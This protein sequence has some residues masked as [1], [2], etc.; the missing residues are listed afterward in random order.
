MALTKQDNNA[1]Q[2]V[3]KKKTFVKKSRELPDKRKLNPHI[4]QNIERRKRYD[5]KYNV[6]NNGN[7][8]N[9]TT[10]YV[11]THVAHYHQIKKIFDDVI[12]KAKN[13][14]E[15]FGN[16]FECDAII[17]HVTF[18]N[19]S[20]VKHSFVDLS[21]PKLYNALI[22][23]LPNGEPNVKY[24]DIE[25]NGVVFKEEVQLAPIIS[26]GTYE[27]DE[28]QLNFINQD[29]DENDENYVT[30]AMI[31]VSPGFVTL[32]DPEEYNLKSLYVSGDVPLNDM[33]FLMS[34]FTRY[35]RYGEKAYPRISIRQLQKDPTKHFAIVVYDDIYDAAFALVMLKRIKIRYNGEDINMHVRND[36]SKK[37]KTPIEM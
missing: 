2:Q 1:F 25:M 15:Y 20:Y 24:I 6:L 18:E 23:K 16:D 22:G 30:T 35:S 9:N 10:L 3:F 34:L 32:E 4:L 14:P 11:N 28:Q 29:L 33:D 26:L 27:Y 5:Y 12:I 8:E 37:F 7:I 21:N 17:N 36:K 31:S 19:G 13:M